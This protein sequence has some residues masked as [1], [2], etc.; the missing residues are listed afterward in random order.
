MKALTIGIAGAGFVAPYHLRAFRACAG[1][2]IGG[3]CDYAPTERLAELG[4][5]YGLR[6]YP[7][8]DEL[9]EDPRIDALVIATRND[10]HLAQV[11]RCQALRKPALVEKP[12]VLELHQLDAIMGSVAKTGIPVMPAHNFVYRGAVRAAW[13]VVQSQKLGRLVCASFGSHHTISAGHM[14]GWRG[15]TALSGGGALMDSGH[16][17]VYQAWYLLGRPQALHAFQSRL[18]LHQM[19][20]EDLAQ[21]HL[22]YAGGAVATITQSWVT[23]HGAPVEGIRIV[24]TE[25]WLQVTDA[26]YVNGERGDTDTAYAASFAN[27]AR[28]FLDVVRGKLQPLSTLS[29]A[30]EVLALIRAAYH[31]AAHNCVVHP[32][33]GG[34][35]GRNNPD[36][37]ATTVAERTIQGANLEEGKAHYLR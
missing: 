30:R 19:A 14:A 12:V 36:I 8:F 26:L 10:Q 7:S 20:G 13:E 25:G 22:L 34:Y 16:H 9:A 4:R 21:I 1:V 11:M 24:G 31:S 23:N 33:F 35:A 27:Q 6:T 2:T 3:I 17:Q 37:D 15:K 29:D 32:P 28:F 5:E 18:K